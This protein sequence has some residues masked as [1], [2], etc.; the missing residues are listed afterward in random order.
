MDKTIPQTNSPEAEQLQVAAQEISR[1]RADLNTILEAHLQFGQVEK[2]SNGLGHSAKNLVKKATRRSLRWYTG[3]QHQ[4]QGALYRLLHDLAGVLEAH[5]AALRDLGVGVQDLRVRLRALEYNMHHMRMSGRVYEAVKAA[6]ASDPVLGQPAWDVNLPKTV[7]ASDLFYCFR[8]LLNRIPDQQEWVAHYS[9]IG[10]DLTKVVASILNS[11]E[12]MQ[13]HLLDRSA[14]AATLVEMPAFKMYV[15][16]DDNYIGGSIIREHEY[17]PF[18]TQLFGHLLPPGMQV[19][20]VGANMGYFS[21]LAASL[22]G[23]S[24]RVYSWE[25]SPSNVKMLLASQLANGFRNIEIVQAAAGSRSG[26]LNYFPNFSNGMVTEIGQ[27]QPE[28]AFAAETV[29]ALR[30]DDVL[31]RDAKIDFVKIDVEG[32]EYEALNGAL[33]TLRRC[34]PLIVSEFCPKSLLS[35][36][37]ISGEDF[38]RFV[39]Q[40]GYDMQVVDEKKLV[41]G[42][43]PEVLAMHDKS[44]IDHIDILFRPR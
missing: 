13:R 2:G 36:S 40:L 3:N 7:T 37:G 44:G 31:P 4:L 16:P 35:S 27:V 32:F 15:S 34:R 26:L 23:E 30:I 42:D 8:L 14:G 29:M 12:F 28:Q 18:L 21:L 38:L 24:G 41:P 33:E 25:P 6:D 11:H 19:L 5:E 10:E 22:V 39:V 17:E 9:R 1:L 20:D 43:I